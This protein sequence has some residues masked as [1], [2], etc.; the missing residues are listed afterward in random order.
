MAKT[1]RRAG[2]G[3]T[4]ECG[5]P[6]PPWPAGWRAEDGRFE[7]P[8]CRARAG[9]ET[10]AVS[11]PDLARELRAIARRLEEMAPAVAALA[12]GG[13]SLL[14]LAGLDSGPTPAERAVAVA[15]ELAGCQVALAARLADDAAVAVA[16]ARARP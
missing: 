11:R 4:C 15:V 1:T 12:G 5:A 9:A 2:A 13:T 16:V 6:M 7:C 10:A 3:E 8:R 14:G